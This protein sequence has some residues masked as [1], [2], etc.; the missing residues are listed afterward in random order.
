M[1]AR[2]TDYFT[3]S[4]PADLDEIERMLADEDIDEL[5]V[6][7]PESATTLFTAREFRRLA[8]AAR[9]AG[10]VLHIVTDDPLRRELALIIGLPVVMPSSTH[11]STQGEPTATAAP[12]PVA[13]SVVDDA[14]TRRIDAPP[15]DR[16][17]AEQSDSATIRVPTSP[18]RGHDGALSVD[19]EIDGGSYSFVISPPARPASDHTD[20]LNASWAAWS[21][22]RFDAATSDSS[23]RRRRGRRGLRFFTLAIALLV[24]AAVLLAVVA[25]A[26]TIAVSP[27]IDSID[28][29]ITYGLAL[30]GRTFDVT[31]D[32]TVVQTTLTASASLA[33]TGERF[34]PDGIAAGS[35]LLTN[36]STS[37][38]F[39]P[40]GTVA[41]ASSGVEYVTT[42]DVV[43][44]AADPYGSMSFGS[45]TVTVQ[46]AAAGSDANAE[47]ETIYGQWDTGLF[48]TNREAIAGGSMKRVATV[49]EADRSALE[50]N[51]R[52]DLDARVSGAI[53]G[54][55]PPGAALLAGSEQRGEIAL[56]FDHAIGDDATTLRVEASL[57]V[58]A[59]VFDP[60]AMRTAAVAEVEN[61][62]RGATGDGQIVAGSVEVDDPRPLGASVEDG[63][64]ISARADVERP[65]DRE[66]LDSLR[67]DAAGEDLGSIVTAASQVDGVDD[68]TVERHYGWLW[69]DM[70][71]LAS[72]IS[73]EVRSDQ[74]T[75]PAEAAPAG[76]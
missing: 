40:A 58:S 56:R 50:A 75:L 33:T 42:A 9:A 28:A 18:W 32:P 71:L 2:Q 7:I 8:L 67:D 14:P 62:L 26:A 4:R 34:V 64:F 43:V 66:A 31:V 10:V 22:R 51:V 15:G 30:E 20:D 63:F 52:A 35:L 72:R 41:Y 45:A 3:V 1:A 38:V 5:T 27:R 16:Q 23:R 11:A 12:E 36:P 13:E 65:V 49:S 46:A 70:P 54:L 21:S 61:R 24:V 6:D 44:P 55:V 53:A 17:P 60:E 76:P 25:P 69:P 74:A 57:P 19:D 48:Y 59:Q 68:V 73:I 39:V 29:R 47:A 37:E